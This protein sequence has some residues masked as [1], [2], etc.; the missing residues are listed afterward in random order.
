M[1]HTAEEYAVLLALL[2]DALDLDVEAREGWIDGLSAAHDGLRPT[3]RRMLVAPSAREAAGVLELHR[4]IAAVV[5]DAMANPLAAE[6]QAGERIGPYELVR[7]I[8]RGGM[9]FVWLANRADGA[10]KR[11]VALKLPFVNWAGRVVERMARER[12]ILAGLEHPNIARFYDAG[13]DAMGRPFMAMELVQGEA[14]DVYCKARALSIRERLGLVLDVAKAVAYAHSKLVVH[15]DL[16]PANMLV[17]ATGAVRLLDFGI[18]K[19]IEGDTVSEPNATQF[20]GRLLTPDYASPEQIRG[21]SIGTATDI[22]SLAVVTYELLTGMRPYRLKRQSAAELEQAIAEADPQIASEAAQDKNLKRQLRGDLDAILNKAM[23]KHAA[24]RYVA[25]EAFA[26]DLQRHLSGEPVLARPDRALYRLRK[27][28]GRHRVVLGA[29]GAILLALV[30]ATSVSLIQAR[31]AQR[32]TIRATATKDF[33][34][35]IF[36]AN[37]PRI[38]SDKPRG[39][40]TA[41]EL[42]EIGSARIEK[43]FKGQPEL[44]IEL[45]GLTADM[46]D[47]MSDEG[48]YAAA[49]KRRIELARAFYGPTHPI[50]ISGLLG[51]ADAAIVREDYVRANQLLDETDASLTISGRDLSPLR[52]NWWR[53]KARVLS[54][55]PGRQADFPPALERALALYEKVA[56]HT[57]DYAAALSLASLNQTERGDNAQAAQLQLRALAVA[58]AAPDRDDSTIADFLYNLARIQERLGDFTAAETTY[59]RAED[60]ARKTYGEHSATYWVTLAYHAHLLHLRG[61]LQPATALFAQMMDAIPVNWSTN[62]QDRWVRETYAEC[63]AAEGRAPEAVPLLEAAQQYYLAHFRGD[64]SVREVRRKLA[65]AYDRLGRTTDARTLLKLAHDESVA[66]DAPASPWVLRM[67]ERWARFLLDHASSDA[68]FAAAELEF[69]TLL[70]QA[71]ERPL[72]EPALARSGLA[73][74]AAARGDFALARRESD[75]ALLALDRVQ[76]LYDVRVQPQLWLV[77]SA[78]LLKSGDAAGARTWAERALEASVRYDVPASAAIVSARNSIRLASVPAPASP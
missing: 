48:H 61:E 74:I 69:R 14:I 39:E 27:L 25:V 77:H 55:T 65:D 63:L 60:Q 6:L 8:G 13:V 33:L 53:E 66:K 5:E 26:G 41:R 38:A 10:F 40:I 73:R 67:R 56:P 46:Y 78:V 44:Q 49:Q 17:T 12:D 71:A 3:L 68:D 43:E 70:E 75:E 34:V 22:Y 54:N 76:G 64:F 37:D 1:K 19:L 18:A 4:H 21:E 36:R 31:E 47:Y 24:D 15:R 29:S 72:A 2:E 51:E 62:G 57:N 42:L 16:K 20:V 23:K 45:L 28:V 35:G 59:G 30:I 50:V 11:S 58:E 32:Q 9:G 7:E 52:A